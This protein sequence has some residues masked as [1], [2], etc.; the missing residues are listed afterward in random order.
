MAEV[1]MKSQVQENMEA[2]F[3]QISQKFPENLPGGPGKGRG[4]HAALC[5]YVYKSDQRCIFLDPGY[6]LVEVAGSQ[7]PSTR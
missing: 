1:Y 4:A 2:V 7:L 6:G 3:R 5:V